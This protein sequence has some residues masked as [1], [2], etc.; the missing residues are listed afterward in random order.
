MTSVI[1][2]HD[3]EKICREISEVNI[4]WQFVRKLRVYGAEL[5]GFKL[6]VLE[7]ASS[8]KNI[9]DLKHA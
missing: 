3:S 7:N 2:G 8:C 1:S 5:I 6:S 9:L 4:K